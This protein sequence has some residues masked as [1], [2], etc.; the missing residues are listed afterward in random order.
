MRTAESLAVLVWVPRVT[1]VREISL[2]GPHLWRDGRKNRVPGFDFLE[3]LQGLLRQFVGT[4]V[5]APG[6]K[7]CPELLQMRLEALFRIVTRALGGDQELPI[8]RFQK[9]QLA[10]DLPGQSAGLFVVPPASRFDHLLYRKLSGIDMFP[11]PGGVG[12]QPDLMGTI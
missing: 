2:A 3:L 7:Q 1:E 8:R 4:F 12:I 9:Q 6:V 11:R 10:A 5:P